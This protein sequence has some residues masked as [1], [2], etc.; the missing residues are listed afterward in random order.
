MELLKLID[1]KNWA[2]EI[3]IEYCKNLSEEN[4]QFEIDGYGNSIK[5]ILGHMYEVSLSWF[6]F[7]I[8]PSFRD[9]PDL[10]KMTKNQIIEGLIEYNQKILDLT[11]TFDLTK[12]YQI[13]WDKNDK[14][15]ETTAENVIFNFVTHSA[16]HRGQLAM[17]LRI[18]GIET[19]IETDFNPYIYVLG[20]K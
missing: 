6:H 15:V 14:M 10:E 17:Y 7:L 1:Y 5:K 9:W 3:Y 2:D 12:I 19:I 20:Q 11:K 4:F 16:Y 8:D 18:T 13:Q